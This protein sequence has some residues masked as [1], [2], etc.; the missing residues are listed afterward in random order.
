MQCV[1]GAPRTYRVR[2]LWW[3]LFVLAEPEVH[4]AATVVEARAGVGREGFDSLLLQLLAAGELVAPACGALLE[5]RTDP[6]IEQRPQ[7]G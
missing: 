2:A 1:G 6:R 5:R 4:G 7:D 3:W